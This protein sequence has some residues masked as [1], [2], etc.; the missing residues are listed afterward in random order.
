MR[1]KEFIEK[2]NKLGWGINKTSSTIELVGLINPAKGTMASIS[3]VVRNLFETRHY[4][5]LSVDDE[6]LDLIVAYT[7]T[8][9]EERK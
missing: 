7:R 8:P 2:A 5:M 1:T 6:T 4:D 3:E 9:V